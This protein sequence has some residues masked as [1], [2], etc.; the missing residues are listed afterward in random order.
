MALN[1]SSLP[2]SA[3]PLP[4]RPSPLRWAVVFLACAMAGMVVILLLWPKR[5]PTAT[6][7]FWISVIGVPLVTA[8]VVVATRFLI[9]AGQERDAQ[10]WDGARDADVAKTFRRESRPIMVLAFGHRFSMDDKENTAATVANG[11]L[12]L[13]A[14]QTP[15]KQA[16]TARWLHAIP[17]ES[18]EKPAEYDAKRQLATL[19][20]LLAGLLESVEKQIR[21]LPAGLP[22]LV[23]LH[24]SAPA[25]QAT[26]EERFRFALK[27]Y[28]LR[29]VSFA[30]D[31]VASDL[32]SLDKWLDMPAGKER[33]HA[34]LLIVVEL[35]DLVSRLPA[36]GS[37][38]AAVA[39]LM[40][41]EDVAQRYRTTSVAQLHRPREGTV[42]T[43]LDTAK[44]ALQWG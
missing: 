6:P 12:L 36:S 10:T 4:E 40:V 32:M 41:P 1:L 27:P 5:F 23:K 2:P 18:G 30:N 9:H 39:M 16:V 26:V 15:S 38:E 21:S 43:L 3:D 25:V 13:K 34:T 37:A 29:D 31:P 8:A 35:H 20:D 14:Q 7:L 42:A 11:E 17:L 19:D 44:L 28:G 22:L 24:V 33:D